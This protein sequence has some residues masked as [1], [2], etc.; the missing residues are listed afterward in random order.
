M[1]FS[2]QVFEFRPPNNQFAPQAIAQC[3]DDIVLNIFDNV[4][5]Y[6]RPGEDDD[7]TSSLNASNR[8]GGKIKVV[9]RRWY[10]DITPSVIFSSWHLLSC[11]NCLF[12]SSS[13]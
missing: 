4:T 11:L 12:N 13:G 10:G 6:I 2:E 7:L 3:R 8:R 9:E 5:T 1:Y